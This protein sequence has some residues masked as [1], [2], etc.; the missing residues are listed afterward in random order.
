MGKLTDKTVLL[1]VGG[2]IAA[3]KSAEIVRRLREAGSHVQVAMTA[4]ATEFIGPLTLQALSGRPVARR[5]LDAREDASIGH[6]TIAEQ[7]DAVLIAPATANLISRLAAGAAD[8]MVTAAVLA[9][10]CPV[11]VAPAMNTHMFEHPAVQENLRKLE[12]FGYRIV[13]P[14]SGVLACGTEGVGRLP[15]AEVLIDE[16]ESVLTPQDL[17]GVRV[18]VSAGPTQEAIDPVRYISNRSSGRMGYAVAAEACR[19]GATVTLVSGPTALV[20]PRGCQTIQVRSASQMHAA[21]RASVAAAEVV[22]MVAAVADY[23]PKTVAQDK[24]KKSPQSLR[25]ELE[26]TE[27]ILSEMSAARGDRIVVGFA[28]E[29]ERVREYARGKLERKGLDLIVANDVSGS[30]TGFDVECNAA[31]ILGRD[32]SETSTGI[33]TKRVLAERIWDRVAELRAS[34]NSLSRRR[35][36]GSDSA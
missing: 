21:A 29:T 12:T 25:L 23:R 20:P 11:V 7:A 15:D 35:L 8:D 4:A 27:D 19:R 34:R 30:E 9:V 22:V 3:Y 31:W 14:D 1:C 18:L 32:G 6:I 26:A 33:L 10:R 2:G 24:L 17:S 36:G 5:I 28:A 13:A 16:V